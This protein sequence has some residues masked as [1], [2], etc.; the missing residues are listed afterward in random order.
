MKQNNSKKG[1]L[2]YNEHRF[3][4]EMQSLCLLVIHG[5]IWRQME[6]RN[7]LC[8]YCKEHIK[9]WTNQKRDV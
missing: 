8:A 9:I 7:F 6:I 2:S 5:N 3:Y 4:A 1:K